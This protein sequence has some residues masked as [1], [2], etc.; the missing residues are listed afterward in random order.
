[1]SES[2]DKIIEIFQKVWDVCPNSY[3]FE[4]STWNEKLFPHPL[5][6]SIRERLKIDQEVT[7]A[8]NEVLNEC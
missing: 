7:L 5:V 3:R 6:P 4:V 1:M 2:E 8:L